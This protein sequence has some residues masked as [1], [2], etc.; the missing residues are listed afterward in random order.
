[1]D[2]TQDFVTQIKKPIES[3]NS[4]ISAITTGAGIAHFLKKFKEEEKH[5]RREK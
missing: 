5:E 1:M 4:I 3:A 2:D